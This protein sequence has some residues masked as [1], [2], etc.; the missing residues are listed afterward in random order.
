MLGNSWLA[1][2]LVV[3]KKGFISMELSGLALVNCIGAFA[4]KN[5]V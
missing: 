1:E 2:R 3:S 5:L 4:E